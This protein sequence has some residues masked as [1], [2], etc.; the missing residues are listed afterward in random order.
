M[1]T[2][3]SATAALERHVSKLHRKNGHLYLGLVKRVLQSGA[4]PIKAACSLLQQKP[5]DYLTNAQQWGNIRKRVV[6]P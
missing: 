6:G 4:D 3:P 1:D 2:A 5:R